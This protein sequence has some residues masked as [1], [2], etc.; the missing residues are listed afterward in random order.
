LHDSGAEARVEVGDHLLLEGFLGSDLQFLVR[1]GPGRF[2]IAPLHEPVVTVTRDQP[3]E[4]PHEALQVVVVEMAE[5][6]RRPRRVRAHELE[7]ASALG[8]AAVVAKSVRHG[9]M[10]EAEQEPVEL[11]A[12]F[13]RRKRDQHVVDADIAVQHEPTTSSER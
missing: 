7:R 3:E 8:R 13:D 12:P 9:P 5:R 11:V 4:H 10:L 6:W 1:D 2:G